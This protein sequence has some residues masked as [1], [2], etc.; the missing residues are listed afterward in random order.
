MRMKAARRRR[1]ANPALIPRDTVR[2]PFVDREYGRCRVQLIFGWVKY[3]K[4]R[5]KLS[6]STGHE[7]MSNS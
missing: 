2:I 6:A 4:V 1:T 3:A 5:R 7:G